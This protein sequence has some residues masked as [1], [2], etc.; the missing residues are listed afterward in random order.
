MRFTIGTFAVALLAGFAQQAVAQE[1]EACTPGT[2]R[3]GFD[4]RGR[5][6]DVLACDATGHWVI[7]DRCGRPGC[8]QL[9]DND[10]PYCNC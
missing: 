7:S 1:G 6:I 9:N 4:S 2:W 5:A 8:C 3:C 10:L